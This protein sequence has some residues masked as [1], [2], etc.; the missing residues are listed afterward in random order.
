MTD[1]FQGALKQTPYQRVMSKTTPQAS[2][3]PV[4]ATGLPQDYTGA[5]FQNW[6]N[7]GGAAAVQDSVAPA[8]PVGGGMFDNFFGQDGWGNL[9]IGGLQT[10]LSAYMGMQ[11]LGMAKDQLNF[12][13]KAFE[14]NYNAQRQSTNTQLRDRQKR[15]AHERPDYYQSVGEY[16]KKNEVK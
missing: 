3:I 13:K 12:Q 8:G 2:S 5:A 16:M 14:K 7:G 1:I 4:G 6:T 15:R 11:Q 10:G 9:A